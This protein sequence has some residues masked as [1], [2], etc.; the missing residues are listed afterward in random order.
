MLSAVS[1]AFPVRSDE[2]EHKQVLNSR[3]VAAFVMKLYCLRIIGIKV[4]CQPDLASYSTCV[5]VSLSGLLRTSINFANFLMGKPAVY[6]F[7]QQRF[8]KQAR[9]QAGDI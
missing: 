1:I 4:K 7:N 6:L 5:L 3:V 8:T 9:C 2:G